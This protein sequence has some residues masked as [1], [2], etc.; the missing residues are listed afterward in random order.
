MRGALSRVLSNSETAFFDQ[1]LTEFG[2]GWKQ[3]FDFGGLVLIEEER[4]RHFARLCAS[5]DGGEGP[6]TGIATSLVDPDHHAVS[7]V[8]ETCKFAFET[9]GTQ[10]DRGGFLECSA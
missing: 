1:E 10:I 4:R 8:M 3:K 7:A 6:E 9:I 5:G 2:V